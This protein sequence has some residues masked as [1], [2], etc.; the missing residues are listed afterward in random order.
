MRAI[1]AALAKDW[2]GRL[3]PEQRAA[4]NAYTEKVNSRWRLGQGPLSGQNL[5]VKLN[6]ILGLI[7]QGEFMKESHPRKWVL[8]ARHLEAGGFCLVVV[9]RVL[10]AI[11]CRMRLVRGGFGPPRIWFGHS[12][13]VRL[14]ASSAAPE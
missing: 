9:G 4:W 6:S 5:Y 12:P 10:A 1:V 3:T 11:A 8:E 2:S 7:G 14:F 13:P